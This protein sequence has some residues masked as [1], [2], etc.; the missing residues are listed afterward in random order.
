LIVAFG[1][2][3]LFVARTRRALGA[4]RLVMFG[5]LC[6]WLAFIF[7][8]QLQFIRTASG[9]DQGRYL[10]PA[11]A[12]LA[13]ILVLGWTEIV[14]QVVS[15]A[16]RHFM[17]REARRAV[18]IVFTAM[19]IALPVLVLFAYTLPAYAQPAAFDPAA[20][21]QHGTPLEANFENGMQLRGYA[22]GARSVSCGDKLAVTLYWTS[23]K[24][25][26][27]TY[28]VFAHLVNAQGVVAGNKDVIPGGGAYPTV[29]WKPNAWLQ[30]TIYV[31]LNE[32]ARAGAY[33]VIVG[34]YK[35]GEPDERVN[36]QNSQGDFVTLG[37]VQVNAPAEGCP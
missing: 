15:R 33:N 20:L 35:F 6:A 36:L 27:E 8:A 11:L 18:G 5:I 1:G 32:G 7:I 13:L 12:T 37:A 14:W 21:A 30:D 16:R 3:L 23:D 4:E 29:Y 2:V 28:R 22:L 24:R 25:I 26:R 17:E 9:T 19:A 31:P 34:V 10:F